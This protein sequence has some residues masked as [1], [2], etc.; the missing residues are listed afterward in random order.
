MFRLD[1]RHRVPVVV[2]LL[3]L[4]AAPGSRLARADQEAWDAIYVGDTKVGHMHLWIK[5]VKDS[6]GRELVNVRVDYDLAFQRGKDLARMRMLYGTIETKEG[7]VL[8]LDTRTQASGGEDIRTFGDV[9]DN[10]MLLTLEIGGRKNQVEVP[11]GPD[12]RGPYGA[13]MSLSRSPIKPGESRTV[14]T[15][16]PDLNKVCLTELRAVDFEEVP[17]GSRAEK[18]K[19][20]RVESVVFDDKSKPIPGMTSTLWI[21]DSGQIMKSKTDLLGG[22]YT[23]RTTKEGAL[24]EG[25]SPFKLLEASILKTPRPIANAEQ[26]TDIVYRVTGSDAALVFPSDHRQTSRPGPTRETATLEV[27][28]DSPNSGAQGP[29][30]VDATY[31]AAN[32]LI[33]SEDPIVVE[34]MKKAVGKR[35]DPWE[36]AVAIQD[37]VFRNMRR[38]N[39]STAFAPAMEVAR[40]LSGDCTEHGVLTAAMCR[41]AGIP[42]RCVIG[43]VYADNLGGFGPHMWNEVYVNRRWVA[44][45]ATFNQSRVDATHIKLSDTSLDGVAPF[46]AFLPVLRVFQSMKLE[47]IEI[48]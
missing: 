4:A 23:Y 26:T 20:L 10:V 16:I 31:L 33:N 22:M 8:R 40:D 14:K 41:A 32:P 46:E 18:R 37:W 12:V 9:R 47:P 25:R 38:K 27:K 6:R 44:I 2:T 34:H 7:T 42:C 29:E 28:S 3:V 35:L 19:L 45:D 11:W 39:F 24:A 36:R 48:R 43:L 21:D 5:P 15:Y 30:T 17:L 13:E 1:L